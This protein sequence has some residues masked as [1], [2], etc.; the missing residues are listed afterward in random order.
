MGHV[1]CLVLGVCFAFTKAPNVGLNVCWQFGHRYNTFFKYIAVSAMAYVI[2]MGNITINGLVERPN[3]LN[4]KPLYC[5]IPKIPALI[6]IFFL[7]YII[8]YSY[9]IASSM[10]V[11]W[12]IDA[13]DCSEM[14]VSTFSI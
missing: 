12:L 6:Q 4:S 1:N 2:K 13:L 9:F 10:S 14:Y 3:R 7:K 8:L 5:M 11:R